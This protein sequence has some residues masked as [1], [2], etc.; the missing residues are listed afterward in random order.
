MEGYQNLGC[1][2]YQKRKDIIFITSM[3]KL[4]ALALEEAVAIK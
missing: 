3:P 4:L 2:F 1:S